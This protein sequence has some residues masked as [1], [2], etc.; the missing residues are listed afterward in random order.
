MDCEV[1]ERYG[2]L[3]TVQFTINTQRNPCRE[4]ELLD[5]FRKD[6]VKHAV[7][8]PYSGVEAIVKSQKKTLGTRPQ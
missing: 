2:F 8:R 1:D 5:I 4:K 3:L 6:M 7:T